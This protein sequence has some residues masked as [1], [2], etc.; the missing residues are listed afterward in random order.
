MII[1][2]IAYQGKLNQVISASFITYVLSQGL[3]FWQFWD[4]FMS[5]FIWF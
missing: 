3:T 2:V 4:S 1:M 5:A